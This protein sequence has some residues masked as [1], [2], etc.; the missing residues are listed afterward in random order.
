[1]S[2][3]IQLN[4]TKGEVACSI[5]IV[6]EEG[7][8]VISVEAS[9]AVRNEVLAIIGSLRGTLT[10]AGLQQVLEGKGYNIIN[11]DLLELEVSL[12]DEDPLKEGWS[13]IQECV[14]EAMPLYSDIIVPIYAELIGDENFSLSESAETKLSEFLEQMY[15]A[16]DEFKDE[17]GH[18]T[19]EFIQQA[20]DYQEKFKKLRIFKSGNALN[21]LSVL[22]HDYVLTF[23]EVPTQT[24]QE[25]S[26]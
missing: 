22:I 1:M 7:G 19:Q 18:T 9:D 3:V 17:G 20:T 25:G 12:R 10:E 21:Q 24:P 16:I 15:Y 4:C 5:L 6:D 13:D 11:A 26:S 8:P 2:E 14:E 23:F